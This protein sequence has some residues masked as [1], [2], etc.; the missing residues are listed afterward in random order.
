MIS[1]WKFAEDEKRDYITPEDITASIDSGA[2]AYFL[3]PIVLTAIGQKKCEDWSLCASVASEMK[4]SGDE[5]TQVACT[6]PP[7]SR[8]CSICTLDDNDETSPQACA[9]R[10]LKTRRYSTS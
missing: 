8:T 1:P 4:G 3:H 7:G 10:A 6:H 2:T 9:A 5:G